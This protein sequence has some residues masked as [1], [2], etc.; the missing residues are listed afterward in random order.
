MQTEKTL[1]YYWDIFL[2]HTCEFNKLDKNFI[3]KYEYELDWTSI[4]KNKLISWDLEF[5]EKYEDRFIWH[6]LAWNDSIVW[7]EV[8][9]DRFKKRL[10][11]YYLG[12]NKNLP[13]TDEFIVKYSKKLFVIEDNPRLTKS[14]TNK[15]K[16]KVLPKNSFDTQE[17]KK[18]NDSD[19]DKI[20]N[21]STFYHNQRVTYD[22]VFNP[23]IKGSSLDKIFET[24]F[25]YS[26]RYYF[27]EPVH[28]DIHG[29]TPEFQI[30]GS[31]PFDVFREGREPFEITNKLTLVNGSI[32]RRSGQA[33]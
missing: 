17:I 5:L 28:Q 31:N 33:I 12:R 14:L 13:I 2:S 27:L 15:Y 24:K 23:I 16:I 30:N 21:K 7:D 22:K 3:A 20:F 4:S 19:F 6:E 10:D 18:Y 1:K 26:Q 32:T 8:K 25:D 9:I 11:W 29:L